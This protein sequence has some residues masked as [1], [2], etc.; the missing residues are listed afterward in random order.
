V[1]HGWVLRCACVASCQ[2]PHPPWSGLCSKE[3]QVKQAKKVQE[4]KEPV[5][6]NVYVA[7]LG[8]CDGVWT[9]AVS[10]L[11]C[12]GIPGMLGKPVCVGTGGV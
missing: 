5:V 11:L 9:A 4:E 2:L 8:L 3:N 12:Y 7:S 10:V 1:I 6:R